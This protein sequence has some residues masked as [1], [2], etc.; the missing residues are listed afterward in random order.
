MDSPENLDRLIRIFH[1]YATMKRD[2]VRQSGMRFVHYTSADAAM[3]M[4]QSRQVWM[5]KSSTMNDFSEIEHGLACVETA[6]RS[7]A[8]KHLKH[9]LEGKF[10]GLVDQLVQAYN[11]WRPHFQMETYLTCISEHGDGQEDRLG[12]LSMW[13]AY[14][15]VAVVLRPDVFMSETASLAAYSTPVEYKDI[16]EFSTKFESIV[17]T[18]EHE[19]D[20]IG[21]RQQDAVF[22]VIFTMLRL[23]V[24]A[25]KHP[26]FVEEREWR[27]YYS[28]TLESSQK[29]RKE[30]EIINGTPQPV[31]KIDLVDDPQSGLN[32][33]EVP[34]LIDRIIIGPMQYPWVAAEAFT[35]LL[36]DAGVADAPS[37]VWISDIPLRQ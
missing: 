8:A 21:N 30:I 31:C 27:V 24:L 33:L 9:T 37:R 15:N 25:T 29:I 1:P 36:S 28:P 3:K 11:S 13:R 34:A 32:G 10:P 17:A 5:R 6:W 7:P 19:K 20:F 23:A 2:E 22:K 14:G 4:I 12:R 16:Q 18:A 26:G 35:Q